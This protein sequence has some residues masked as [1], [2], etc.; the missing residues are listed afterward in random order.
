MLPRVRER[1]DNLLNSLAK[2]YWGLSTRP[3]EP[4][5]IYNLGKID[6]N[7]IKWFGSE[8]VLGIE[9]GVSSGAAAWAPAV[10]VASAGAINLLLSFKERSSFMTNYPAAFFIDS[11]RTK[12]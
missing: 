5:A 6:R 7:L 10:A 1:K 3:A 11:I 12:T 9:L 4:L 2:E 8:S